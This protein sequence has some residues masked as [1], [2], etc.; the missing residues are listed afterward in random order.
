MNAQFIVDGLIAGSMIG[1][2]AIGVTLTYAILRFANFAHG[3][4]IAW[5][6]YLALA[7]VAAVPF[8][9]VPIGPFSFGWMLPI[10]AIAAALL[11]GGLAILIDWLLFASFRR[12]GSATIIMVTGPAWPVLPCMAISPHRWGTPLNEISHTVRSR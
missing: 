4:F 10:A 1:L 5:G 3:E 9:M 2:G 11:T 8:G 6:A 12:R 7:V